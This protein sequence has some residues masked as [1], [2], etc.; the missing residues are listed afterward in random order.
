MAETTKGLA[1]DVQPDQHVENMFFTLLGDAIE[2]VLVIPGFT[3]RGTR[4]RFSRISILASAVLIEAAANSVFQRISFPP[5][6]QK[7]L[8]RNLGTFDKFDMF[9]LAL[10]Q[11]SKFERGRIE[12]QR[13]DD[14]LEIRNEYVHPKLISRPAVKIDEVNGQ[15]TFHCGTY[16]FLKIEKSPRAWANDEAIRVLKA[17]D[18]FLTYFF[19]EH[20]GLTPADATRYLI[21]STFV[22]GKLIGPSVDLHADIGY[23][24]KVRKDF[25]IPFRFV[26]D[27]TAIG[28]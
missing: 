11:K 26:D 12:T 22:A 25:G 7:K 10:F 18:G 16:E 4:L 28:T 23:V 20:G 27:Q 6:V 8:E 9:S 19:L 17:V 24:N 21:P 14:L 13:I 5:P 15:M 2:P 1:G 3:N